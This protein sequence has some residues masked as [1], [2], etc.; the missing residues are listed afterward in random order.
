[1]HPQVS[2]P[3][4]SLTAKEAL[5]C[6]VCDGPLTIPCA[7]CGQPNCRDHLALVKIDAMVWYLCHDCLD[8]VE[9]ALR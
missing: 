3:P 1:M 2:V 4:I 7:K 6:V 5:S 9:G 8:D